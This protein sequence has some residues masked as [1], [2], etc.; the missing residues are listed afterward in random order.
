MEG[1]KKRKNE[2]MKDGRRQSDAKG[3]Q[4]VYLDRLKNFDCFL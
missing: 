3:G 2:W 1:K 4:L